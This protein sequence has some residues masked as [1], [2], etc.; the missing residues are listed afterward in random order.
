MTIR[1]ECVL[2]ERQAGA[3][4]IG[5]A[6]DDERESYRR[7]LAGCERCL[8]ELSGE[9]EIER[10]MMAVTRARDDERW[11]PDLRPVFARRAVRRPLWVWAG[12]LAAG[13]VLVAAWRLAEAPRP[14][15][16]QTISAL[17]T[18]SIAALGTQTAPRRE[19]RAESLVVG[20][21]L[22]TASLSVSVD[23]RG[24]PLHCSIVKSSGS[25][26]LDESICRAAL[27]APTQ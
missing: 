12:A 8:H 16:V 26:A 3:I 17:E 21:K 10:I 6:G 4:A 7:H 20:A 24:K 11:E 5:E 23:Q 19:G 27:H 18:R 14:A 1:A 22:L 2:A 9:R 15:T 13:I 25:R